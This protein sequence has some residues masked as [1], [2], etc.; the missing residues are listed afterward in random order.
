MTGPS[1]PQ[2]E[3]LAAGTDPAGTDHLPD[4]R[5]LIWLPL[6]AWQVAAL[7]GGRMVCVEIPGRD[8]A[9]TALVIVNPPYVPVDRKPPTWTTT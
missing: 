4:G 7:Q 5:E 9:P 6:S 2:R 8:D 1:V 3:A